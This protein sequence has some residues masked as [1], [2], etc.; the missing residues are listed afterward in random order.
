MTA[1][2]SPVRSGEVPDAVAGVWN[3]HA[4]PWSVRLFVAAYPVLVA[5]L[6][7]R[8]WRLL[9]ATLTALALSFRVVEPPAT[10][11][12]WATRVVRGEAVWLREGLTSRPVTLAL[13]VAGGL[14]QLATIRAA[15]RREPRRTALGAVTSLLAMGLFFDRMTRIADG[16][17]DADAVLADD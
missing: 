15:V 9:V 7:R 2:S 10:D 14:V 12:A 4:N 5:G 3:R 16:D 17:T 13:T 8:N 11:D 6:Y 1:D